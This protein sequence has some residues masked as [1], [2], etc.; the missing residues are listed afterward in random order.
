M[1]TANNPKNQ[2]SKAEGGSSVQITVKSN[3]Y[4]SR[5]TVPQNPII[6]RDW[7]TARPLMLLASAFTAHIFDHR[8]RRDFGHG[9]ATIAGGPLDAPTWIATGCCKQ[10]RMPTGEIATMTE[11]TP[12]N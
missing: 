8:I 5:E 12:R 1:T 6:L 11:E 10:A 7:E 4:V 9:D 2:K 3:T